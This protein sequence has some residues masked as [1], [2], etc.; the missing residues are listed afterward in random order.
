MRAL[1]YSLIFHTLRQFPCSR[2]IDAHTRDSL[3]SHQSHPSPPPITLPS[4]PSPRPSTHPVTSLSSTLPLPHHQPIS[5]PR[6]PAAPRFCILL[7]VSHFQLCF[8]ENSPK[9]NHNL[10]TD[11]HL[12][13]RPFQKMPDQVG[14]EGLSRIRRAT[15][16]RAGPGTTAGHRVRRLRAMSAP[17]AKGAPNRAHRSRHQP[18]GPVP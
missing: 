14:Q 7:I 3:P 9:Q 18:T 16:D 10:L 13:K 8:G 4:P 1:E 17:R 12:Q 5:S 6:L 15:V 2:I 11:K